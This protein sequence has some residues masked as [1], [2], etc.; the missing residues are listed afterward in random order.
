MRLKLARIRPIGL[1]FP[2]RC[3]RTASITS[4]YDLGSMAPIG[5]MAKPPTVLNDS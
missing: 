1:P 5:H 3:S 2:Y 4:L